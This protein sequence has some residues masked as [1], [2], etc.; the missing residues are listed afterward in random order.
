MAEAPADVD[1]RVLFTSPTLVVDQDKCIVVPGYASLLNNWEGTILQIKRK[2]LPQRSSKRKLFLCL[3][4]HEKVKSI[5]RKSD[6]L[7]QT[8][9][10]AFT[11]LPNFNGDVTLRLGNVKSDKFPLKCVL[12]LCYRNANC[13]LVRNLFDKSLTRSEPIWVI[14]RQRASAEAL[15]MVRVADDK[16]RSGNLFVGS[17]FALGVDNGFTGDKNSTV[18]VTPLSARAL[19][20]L[21]S[22]GITRVLVFAETRQSKTL[23]KIQLIKAEAKEDYGIEIRVQ[24]RDSI[25]SRQ[26]RSQFADLVKRHAPNFF[27]SFFPGM[28]HKGRTLVCAQAGVI[29]NMTRFSPMAIAAAV[30]SMSSV[31][32]EPGLRSFTRLKSQIGSRMPPTFWTDYSKLLDSS[33]ADSKPTEAAAAK[34]I[35]IPVKVHEPETLGSPIAEEK[36]EEEFSPKKVSPKKDSPVWR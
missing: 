28:K 31:F 16:G 3:Q 17:T 29:E 26:H 33:G 13:S 1:S 18:L 7:G 2:G 15:H 6:F 36:I 4:A 34:V 20:N 14:S 30:A 27:A 9:A 24:V 32:S 8:S 12:R 11:M 25:T 23:S 35:G 19:H 5:I 22:H 21:R 10:D